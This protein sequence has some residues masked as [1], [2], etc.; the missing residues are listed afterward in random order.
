MGGGTV[1]RFPEMPSYVGSMR[2][3]LPLVKGGNF[4]IVSMEFETRTE[5]KG[6]VRCLVPGTGPAA[7]RGERALNSSFIM[8]LCLLFLI[9][10]L[11]KNIRVRR[12]NNGYPFK[13]NIKFS[14]SVFADTV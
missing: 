4:G 9:S 11:K 14:V 13:H 12:K 3:V 7:L 2:G 6:R 1:I 8:T 10:V 5:P